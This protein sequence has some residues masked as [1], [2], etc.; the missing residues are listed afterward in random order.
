MT[1][2]RD[3]H[4]KGL[5]WKNN[6]SAQGQKHFRSDFI[7]NT[8]GSRGTDDMIGQ[9]GSLRLCDVCGGGGKGGKGERERDVFAE[10]VG[11]PSVMFFGNYPHCFLSHH[12]SLAS[13]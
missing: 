2:E 3:S 7:S 8:A 13:R 9:S 10:T 1:G 12:L 6:L 5:K 4:S 11:Q